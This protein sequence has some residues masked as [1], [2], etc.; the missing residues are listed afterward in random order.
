MQVLVCAS[1]LLCSAER[2]RQRGKEPTLSLAVPR[3]KAKAV[4]LQL[5]A[6][7]VYVHLYILFFFQGSR[8]RAADAETCNLSATVSTADELQIR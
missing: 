6:L 1:P 2:K 7:D 8:C 5:L 3:G 4:F